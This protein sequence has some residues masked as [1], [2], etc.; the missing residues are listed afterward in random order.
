MYALSQLGLTWF[1]GIN[2]EHYGHVKLSFFVMAS[3]LYSEKSCLF[4]D[5]KVITPI[6]NQCPCLA[7]CAAAA[8]IEITGIVGQFEFMSKTIINVVRIIAKCTSLTT[9]TLL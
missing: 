3:W 9:L 2:P 7:Y 5:I 6:Y 1:I 4:L 8:P